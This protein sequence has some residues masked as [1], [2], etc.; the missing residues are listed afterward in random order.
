M[1]DPGLIYVSRNDWGSY[2]STEDFIRDRYSAAPEQKT[3]IQVHHTAAIDEDDTTPNRWDK[4]EA[5]KYMQRLQWSRP[6]LKPLPYSVNL[7]TNEDVDVV[8]IFEGRGIL[9]VGAHTAD[10]NRDGVGFGVFGNFDK[11]DDK[12]AAVLVR[13]IEIV[14]HDLRYGGVWADLLNGGRLLPN[15]GSVRNPKGWV[16]WGHR[17]SSPKS[18][19]G[20]YLYPLLRDF[21]LKGDDVALTERQENALNWLA[22]QLEKA[23][24]EAWAVDAVAELKAAGIFS[25]A[26]RPGVP[27]SEERLATILKRA[28]DR[29]TV[30]VDADALVAGVVN[31]LARRLA[32]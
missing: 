2:Q 21:E 4:D 1:T 5:V 18:C 7:A 10:H 16:A 27:V 29:V 9:K 8:W 6:D 12:A 17:D 26:Y 24:T 11:S 31:E 14:C 19:P 30:G 32:G 3:T 22:D 13:A 25:D 28:L 23:D 15:L 20:N